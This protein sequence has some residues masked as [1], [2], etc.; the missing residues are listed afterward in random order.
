MTKYARPRPA[1]SWE[2]LAGTISLSI[3]GSEFRYPAAALPT[4]GPGVLAENRIKPIVEPG[5]AP[6]N[7][8]V[9]GQA[10]V[11]AGGV[12]TRIWQSVPYAQ[13]EGAGIVWERIK[14]RRD[15]EADGGANTPLGRVDTDP[16]SRLRISGA[17]QMAQISLAGGEPFAIGWTMADNTVVEHDGPAMIAMGVAA[18]QK[19]A[20]CFARA[21]ALRL[22]VEAAADPF[23]VDYSGGWPA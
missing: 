8:R 20:A 22:E 18:G 7:V 4:L 10:I 3:D 19:Y 14:A 16:A 21:Q 12:P 17:V 11:D 23:A 5:P 9:L 15:L 1:G 2:E 6:E 13:A